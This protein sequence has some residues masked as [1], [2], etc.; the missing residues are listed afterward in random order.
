MTPRVNLP[1][2]RN[3]AL[4]ASLP[5]WSFAL[6]STIF[7]QDGY[8]LPPAPSENK[9][10]CFFSGRVEW[11]GLS[12]SRIAAPPT[13]GPISGAGSLLLL[14]WRAGSVAACFLQLSKQGALG[15]KPS[16]LSMG[17]RQTLCHNKGTMAWMG[18]W[19]DGKVAPLLSVSTTYQQV[20]GVGAGT[21]LNLPPPP[22]VLFSTMLGT[23]SPI[24]G[25]KENSSL[26]KHVWSG[27]LQP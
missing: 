2:P 15:R 16:V 23:L 7:A 10:T 17:L 8:Q 9:K 25:A 22:H 12:G 20:I 3:V 6:I 27:V 1:L 24:S 19:M 4:A 18:W 14:E 26:R 11:G 21:V 5:A 13:P